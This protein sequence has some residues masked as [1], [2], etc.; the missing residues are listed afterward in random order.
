[1]PDVMLEQARTDYDDALEVSCWDSG[2]IVGVATFAVDR[3]WDGTPTGIRDTM[4]VRIYVLSE[5]A[6]GT[7][8]NVPMA[9]LDLDAAREVRDA[10]DAAILQVELTRDQRRRAA[11]K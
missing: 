6:Q 5:D 9:W 1:M 3:H 8:E 7:G 4:P 2:D 10:I 11:A